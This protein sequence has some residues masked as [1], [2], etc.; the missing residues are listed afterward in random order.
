MTRLNADYTF[1]GSR[2]NKT[3]ATLG[4]S[5]VTRKLVAILDAISLVLNPPPQLRSAMFPP[6]TVMQVAL[7]CEQVNEF[8]VKFI[9]VKSLRKLLT[10]EV[11]AQVY[12]P[13]SQRSSL[14]AVSFSLL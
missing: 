1:L 13:A 11:N 4:G 8:G 6:N 2:L 14:L 10:S 3:T 12:L 9:N 5:R 7:A